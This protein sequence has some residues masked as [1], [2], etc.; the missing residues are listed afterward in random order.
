L[1]EY[2]SSLPAE[3]VNRAKCEA[4]ARRAQTA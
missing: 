1:V 3:E 4:L 2:I